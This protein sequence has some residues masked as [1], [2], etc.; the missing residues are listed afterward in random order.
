MRQILR[1]ILL[2]SAAGLAALPLLSA[3][4]P[5]RPPQ[6]KKVSVADGV[7]LHYVERGKGVPVVFVHGGLVDYTGWE[8]QLGPFAESYRAIAYSCRYNYPNTNKLQPKYSAVVEAE[9]LAALIKKLDL[10][11]VHVVGLSYGAYTA[12]FLAVKHPDLVRSL[13]LAEPPVHFRGD[14]VDEARARM[15]KVARAAFEKGKPEEAVQ[16]VF[17]VATGGKA[18]FDKFPEVAKKY[19]LRNAR[20]LEAMVN[21][22][23]FPEIDR[24]AIRKIAAPTLLM[25]GEKS[26]PFFKP[27]DKELMRLLPEKGRQQVTI[28][29]A[30]HG[31]FRSHAEQCRKAILEFL[32]GK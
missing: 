10:G 1:F 5:K 23:C 9:D 21:G 29:G 8:N 19:I 12:L 3:Q 13:V 31:M 22:D 25:S 30:D 26:P 32:R 7:E 11:K 16:A 6:L 17:D 28:R 14:P 27:I 2:T 20:Q 24:D 15:V 4:E 18:K